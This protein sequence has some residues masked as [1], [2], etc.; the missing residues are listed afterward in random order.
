MTI[1]KWVECVPNF[2]EGRNQYIIQAIADAIQSV[3][4]VLLLHI[5]SSRDANRSVYTFVGPPE[6]VAEAAYRSIIKALAL[7]DMRQQK[8]AH[9]RMGACDV[10]PLIPMGEFTM[11]ETIA[12]SKSL[13]KRLGDA[14]IPV[15]LYEYSALAPERRNLAFLRKG[16]YESIPQKLQNERWKPDY[17]PQTFHERFGM[18]ALGARKFLI[19]Y[20]INLQT[21]D[22][23]IA[24]FVASRIRESG[25]LD[26]QGILRAGLLKSVKAIGWYLHEYRCAQVSTNITD[27]EV[28]GIK[29]V[30]DAVCKVAE[31]MGVSVSGS[32]L[33]GLI[34]LKALTDAGKKLLPDEESTDRLIYSALDYLQLEIVPEERI[35]EWAI[36]KKMS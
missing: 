9:P 30:Y 34:P 32:E 31:S 6:A 15:Y 17:G 33:V 21:E 1:M 35:L 28:S 4:E 29:E 3:E 23:S 25:Y 13:G 10:C 2:S 12:L 22:V 7:I 24:G 19:A 5:D 16:E 18:M 11:E 27:F 26:A 20:N 36:R 14:G 8:G